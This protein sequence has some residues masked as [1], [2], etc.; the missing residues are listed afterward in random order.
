[1]DFLEMYWLVIDCHW[2]FTK[3]RA[4]PFYEEELEWEKIKPS[5]HLEAYILSY[6]EMHEGDLIHP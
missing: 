1:M 6:F 4:T 2:L 5:L 3:Y